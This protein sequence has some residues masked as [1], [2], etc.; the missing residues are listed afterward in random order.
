MDEDRESCIEESEEEIHSEHGSTTDAENEEINYWE[1]L[2]YGVL[3]FPAPL[4][5]QSMLFII[6]HLDE[7]EN[8]TLAL[9]PLRT[10]QTLLLNLPVIDVCKLEGSGVTEDIDM[11][12]VWKT[13]YYNRLPTHPKD[14][15]EILTAM[16]DDMEELTWKDR[17]F[18]SLFLLKYT[19][20]H[21]GD[22]DCNC[23]YSSHLDQDLL[24]G[25]YV[26]NGTLEV[27]ECFGPRTHSCFGVE[28]YAR[29]CCRLTP[30]R[31]SD[32][33]PDQRSNALRRY[34]RTPPI[35]ICA[36][37]PT[38]V[39]VCKFEAKTF[40]VTDRALNWFFDAK[41]F[42]DD[43]FPYWKSFL[44]SVRWLRIHHDEEQLH[45]GLKLL[46]DAIF[47]STHCKLNEVQLCQSR[48]LYKYGR[49]GETELNQFI[50][51]LAPYFSPTPGVDTLSVPYA[52]LR[53]VNIVDAIRSGT[54]VLNTAS[55][56][57]YQDNLEVVMVRGCRYFSS[58]T[59]HEQT[60]CFT[61]A[62]AT[63][64]KKSSFQELCLWDMTVPTSLVVKLVHQF[65][66]SQSPNHQQLR[67]DHVSVLP[68]KTGLAISTPPPAV[69]SRSMEI[70]E[71]T[72]P[73]EIASAFPPSMSFRNLTLGTEQKGSIVNV[74]D[75]F[76]HVHS[77]QVE[78]MSLS[79]YTSNQN[80][81]AIV[82]LLNLVDTRNWSL[83]FKF[84]VPSPH[85]GWNLT[86]E[87][88]ATVVD[89]VM[90]IAPTLGQLVAKGIVT[91]LSFASTAC[92]DKLPESVLEALFEEIFRGLQ[93]SRSE[94]ELDLRGCQLNNDIL[95][96]LYRTWKRCT[97]VKLKKLDLSF[98][99]LPQDK[100]N[101]HQMTDKLIKEM[102]M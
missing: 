61:L 34:D 87:S 36:T 13:L 79:V 23:V 60:D 99:K 92:F 80:S 30:M 8:E 5:I 56:I 4:R 62:L 10:R 26:R 72:L 49:F 76:S 81:K 42:T 11:E 95:E 67:F 96:C 69:G 88:I 47:C 40:I 74:L 83:H 9:L 102:S 2:K 24:Y 100:S 51:F 17:Y 94:V 35:T 93:R 54:D 45:P 43:Y 70:T 33:F 75:L 14:F 55:I 48:S 25:M 22:D 18:S 52:H 28:T 58:E 20:A 86:P 84:V 57:N 29:S 15:E 71:C 73:L 12:E 63:L 21:H 38:L 7:Y 85:C 53:K 44:G 97:D 27:Q 77:L 6:G 16:V 50:A 39:D 66:S 91:L 82:K 78:S 90:D 89:A 1:S 31:Y 98:N 41:C 37:I 3:P 64:V 32:L 59:P 68:D 101:L 46:L 65:F 19:V